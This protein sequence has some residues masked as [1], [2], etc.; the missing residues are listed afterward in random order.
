L[1]HTDGQILALEVTPHATSDWIHS[2]LE[3]VSQQVGTPLQIIA[4]RAQRTQCRY[5]NLQRLLNWALHILH[6]NLSQALSTVRNSDLS[7]WINCTFGQSMLSKRKILF[8][9]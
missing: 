4:D 6:S 1:K 8:S 2:V 9:F 7:Q 3:S 5:F